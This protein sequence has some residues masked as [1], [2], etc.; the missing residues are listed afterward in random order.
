MNIA[1]QARELWAAYERCGIKP[2]ASMVIAA[3]RTAR[4]KFTNDAVRDAV[5]DLAAA[6]PHPLSRLGSAYRK[7]TVGLPQEHD[8]AYRE[9]TAGTPSCDASADHSRV[10]KAGGGYQDSISP[11]PPAPADAESVDL[12]P[13]LFAVPDL[14]AKPTLRSVA[15]QD[16]N[17]NFGEF[18]ADVVAMIAVEQAAHPRKKPAEGVIRQRLALLWRKH[19]DDAFARGLEVGVS[20]GNGVNYGRAVMER[21]DPDAE[22]RRFERPAEGNASDALPTLTELIAAGKSA[23]INSAA[24]LAERP[25]W[26]NQQI[27]A[28][29]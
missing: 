21:F 2:S 6:S 9:P 29:A 12:A 23:A 24:V 22:G 28:T 11:P 17:T 5:K 10:V 25:A 13:A 20:S 15:A 26:F 8:S 1:D 16:P 7:P 14:P 3:L 27:A 4:I 19:G 18:E